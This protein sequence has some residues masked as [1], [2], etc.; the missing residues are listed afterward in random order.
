[1][2][3]MKDLNLKEHFYKEQ[4]NEK[5]YQLPVMKNSVQKFTRHLSTEN[6][7][8]RWIQS[9]TDKASYGTF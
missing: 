2:K 7:Y 8:L 5:Q 1:M 4:F 9:L 6:I 3:V